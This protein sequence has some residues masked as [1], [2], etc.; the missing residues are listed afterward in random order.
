MR[1]PSEHGLQSMPRNDPTA[2][3]LVDRRTALRAPEHHSFNPGVGYVSHSSA[4]MRNPGNAPE[5]RCAPP[6]GTPADTVHLLQP[7]GERP[8][9]AFLWTARRIWLVEGAAKLKANR[10]G[11][12]D[13]YLSRAGWTY[14][15]GIS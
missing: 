13:A 3:G 12:P 2:L 5:D 4:P 14:L 15:R 10:M 1:A 7:P 11:Y 8:P 6:T 9:M